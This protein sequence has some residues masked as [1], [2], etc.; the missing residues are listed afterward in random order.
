VADFRKKFGYTP[1]FYGAQSYD[2][3]MLIDSAVRGVKGDL[4][5]KKGMVATMR[6]ADFKS[7]RGKFTYNVNH[8]PIENF[9]LLKTVKGPTETEMQIQKTIFESH[10]DAYYQECPMKW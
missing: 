4:A 9:Y 1:S 8:H 5:N 2:G 6:K 10:K 3:I 7:T